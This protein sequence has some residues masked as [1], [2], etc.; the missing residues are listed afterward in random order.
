M[1]LR[2]IYCAFETFKNAKFVSSTLANTNELDGEE[3]IAEDE[4]I[5]LGNCIEDGN[6]TRWTPLHRNLQHHVKSSEIP[7]DNRC[8]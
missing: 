7:K 1:P 6:R 3:N 8:T 4:S 2:Y 5:P